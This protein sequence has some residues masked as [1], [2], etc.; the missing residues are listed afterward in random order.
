MWWWEG[1]VRRVAM[2]KRLCRGGEM[3]Q[4]EGD[5]LPQAIGLAHTR[6]AGVGG[7]GG[8]GWKDRANVMP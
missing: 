2:A 5:A 7:A 6:G 8:G 3:Y 4:G 1:D